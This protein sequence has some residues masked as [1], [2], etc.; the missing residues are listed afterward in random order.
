MEH[1][2]AVGGYDIVEFLGR[3]AMGILFRA[4]DPETHEDVALKLLEPEWLRRVGTSDRLRAEA[5]ALLRLRHPN[6][7]RYITHG[8]D[9]VGRPFLVMEFLRG[10]PLARRATVHPQ[11]SLDEKLDVVCQLCDALHYAHVEGVIHQDVKPSNIWLTEDGT[12]KLVDFGIASLDTSGTEPLRLGS[13][14][15]V[16]PERLKSEPIDQR[17][18]VF[19]AGVVLYE[20]LAAAHPFRM[21]TPTATLQRVLHHEPPPLFLRCS[22]DAQTAIQSAV[23][24]ALAKETR[25][26]YL[27]ADEF[28]LDLRLARALLEDNAPLPAADQPP[29]ALLDET[30]LAVPP[31]RVTTAPRMLSRATEPT[32][33]AFEAGSSPPSRRA[34]SSALRRAAVVV[35]AAVLLI[36][37]GVVAAR[38]WRSSPPPGP[39]VTVTGP[40]ISTEPAGARVAIDGVD[41]GLVTPATLPRPLT[42]GVRVTLTLDGFEPDEIELTAGSIAPVSRTLS[43]QLVTAVLEAPFLFK[44]LEG[45]TLLSPEARSHRL[46][47]PPGQTLRLRAERLLLDRAVD[48]NADPGEQFKLT[49]PG[50]GR[51][52]VRARDE[53]CLIKLGDRNLGNPPVVEYAVV[54]GRHRME[55]LCPGKGMLIR[56]VDVHTG[57]T[58]LE[59]VR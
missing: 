36:S 3:G 25:Q 59:L 5:A 21:D 53:R 33:D 11:L 18:D 57:S 47:V 10:T 8:E 14:A 4:R 29:K 22:A 19:S 20:L 56:T 39:P 46:Q 44:V 2:A 7:V 9:D 34:G 15:Y 42:A 30:I 24:R 40:P 6:I 28:G 16:S 23:T 48:I 27:S 54:A 52:T 13:P 1:P 32:W 12:V 51:V 37:G 50:T 45:A 26:R 31:S 35:A 49:L 17:T 58:T 41:T 43:R 55:L 38:Y